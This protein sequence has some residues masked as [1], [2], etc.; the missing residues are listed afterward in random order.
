MLRSYAVSSFRHR[1]A[2]VIA[3]AIAAAA[4]PARAD[5]PIPFSARSGLDVARDAR[6][7][8]GAGGVSIE[9]SPTPHMLN[10]ESV[11]TY[12][13]A[14]TIHELA[15]GR[16]ITG[17]SAFCGLS[18]SGRGASRCRSRSTRPRAPSRAR[19]SPPARTS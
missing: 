8:L 14:A 1:S 18:G 10:L 7:I 12:E 3:L 13:G 16:G 19:R 2:L 11:L 5:D 6:D 15:L 9:W 4:G 17:R